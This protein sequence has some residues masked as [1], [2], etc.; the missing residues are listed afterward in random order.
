MEQR[1]EWDEQVKS[2]ELH[3]PYNHIELVKARNI[4]SRRFRKSDKAWICKASLDNVEYIAH[5]WPKAAW[6]EPANTVRAMLLAKGRARDEQLAKKE[7]LV[8]NGLDLSVLDQV[9]FKHKPFKHQA[10][11]L[12]L[13]RDQDEFAYL[14]DQGTGKTKTLIDDAAHNFRNDRIDAL[15]VIAPNSVKTNWISWEGQDEIANHMP[16]DIK[17]VKAVWISDANAGERK[18]WKDFEIALAR[19]TR[20]QMIALA[21]NIDA[22][23]VPRLYDFLEKFCQAFRTMIV[24]DESTRI[25]TPSAQRTRAV[26]KLRKLCK[27]AR[28]LSGTPVIKSPLDAYSQFEFLDP[29]ILRFGSFYAFRNRYAVMGG[30]ENRVVI[31]YRNLDELTKRI[32]SC[33]YRVTKEECLDLPPKVYQKRHVTITKR[34]SD[35]YMQMKNDMVVN[36]KDNRVEAPIVLTQLLRFQQITGGYLPLLD[37]QGNQIGVQEIVEPKNN[38]KI[39]ELLDILDESGDQKFIV[40]ARFTHEIDAI[41]TVLSKNGINAVRFDGK[42]SD[43][44]KKANREAF[45]SNPEIKGLVGNQAAGGIGLDLYAATIVIYFSNS[46][47]T[48]QRVQ[49]EDRAHRIGTTKS[50]TYFDLIMPATVDVKIVATLRNNKRIAAEVMQDGWKDWI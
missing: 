15:L 30:F 7:G 41:L 31:H 40:W 23:I 43:S 6:S 2:F 48:E 12:L 26:K 20:D 3:L 1:V 21:I 42:L 9:P 44:E 33:S 25:K 28:I 29:N 11:A 14:M 49:S 34:Q 50:V 10:T 32:S 27:M 5:Q 24:V 8:Q 17:Y 38:P 47:D 46:F 18:A 19:R 22:I 4:P 13:G 36:F 39:K 37:E 35:C 45:Q 16:P